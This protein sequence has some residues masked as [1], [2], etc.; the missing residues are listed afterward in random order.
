[1]V[2]IGYAVSSEEHAPNDIVRHARRAEEIGFPYLVISDHYHPWV[3]H[4]GHS[5]FVWNVLGAIAATTTRIAVATGVTCPLI[6]LH[7]AILAQAAATTAAMMPNR[8]AFGLGLGERL[9]EHILGTHWPPHETRLEMLAEAV[10]I[11][12]LLW[13]G[14]TCSY[15]GRFYTVENARLYT[16]PEQPPP[17]L[18]AAAGPESAEVAGRLGDGLINI[19]SDKAVVDAFDKGGGTTKPKY[20]KMTVCWAADEATARRTALEWWPLA[21]LKGPQSTEL[22]LPEHF[23]AAS[24]DAT[25]A[26]MAAAFVCSPDPAR[27]VAKIEEY[28][29][30]GFDH[31][32]VHQ[33]GPDQ[34]GFFAFYQRKVLPRFR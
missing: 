6:R 19:S 33:L 16:R 30:A 25:E 32:Y 22:A 13:K 7:P 20:G 11:L 23:E 17:I 12:R 14:E 21:S 24:Q 9:N 26:D 1:M 10:E 4:Q 2:A 15:R 28:V 29:A 3:P 5:P 8:F 31:V 18:I 34:E 27:H